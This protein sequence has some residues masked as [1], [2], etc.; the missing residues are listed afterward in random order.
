[1][2]KTKKILAVIVIMTMVLSISSCGQKGE[3]SDEV[4]YNIA[5]TQGYDT[6]NFFTTES[7]LVADWLGVC[8]DS[9]IG[10][11]KDYNA[12]PKVA[13]KW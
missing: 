3:S 12:I 2:K 11:D 13:E 5:T 1:M 8:Y 10:Y 7:D 4:I 9:L 6:F